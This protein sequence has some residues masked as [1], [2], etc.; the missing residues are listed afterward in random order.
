[1][2]DIS[3]ATPLLFKPILKEK[4]WGGT[5]FA[6]VFSKHEVKNATIGESWELSG[7]LGNESVALN[8]MVKDQTLTDLFNHHR[9]ELIGKNTDPKTFPLLYKFIDA[10]ERLSVQVHPTDS[11]A[12]AQGYGPFGKTECWYVVHAIPGAQIIC[13]FRPNVTIEDVT[14]ASASANI[15]GLLNYIDVASGDVFLVP[16]GTVHA[17]LGGL[18]FYEVQETSD[19][20]FRLYDWNRPDKDGKLRQLH[21]KESLEAIDTSYHTYH[22]I[23]PII[24]KKNQSHTHLFRAACRHFVLEEYRFHQATSLDFPCKN[25]FQVITVCN[26]SAA[27]TTNTEITT[28]EKGKTCLLPAAIQQCSIQA[29]PGTIVLVSSVPDLKKDVIEPLIQNG[30]SMEDI[31]LLGGNPKT[32]DLGKISA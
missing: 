5:A 4:I 17:I 30:I 32:S 10:N 19:T 14:K 13:G 22:K 7:I 26:G 12:C 18:L 6:T 25:T 29:E 9:T 21:I 31:I 16:G 8:S 15:L 28:L 1:L 20:T 23:K 11:Q 24:I 27:L 3:I 2:S